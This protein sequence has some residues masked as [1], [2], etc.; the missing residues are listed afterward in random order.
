MEHN[1]NALKFSNIIIMILVV[2]TLSKWFWLFLHYCID[3]YYCNIIILNA[4]SLKQCCD[5]DHCN[6]VLCSIFDTNSWEAATRHILY[7]CLF[8][9]HVSDIWYSLMLMII[10]KRKCLILNDILLCIKMRW[11]GSWWFPRHAWNSSNRCTPGSS[12]VWLWRKGGGAAR[13]GVRNIPKTCP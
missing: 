7:C 4:A 5:L 10:I 2:A 8:A 6:I 3:L 11:G 13:E 9:N 12:W 1:H